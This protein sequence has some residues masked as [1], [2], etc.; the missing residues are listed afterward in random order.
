MN[1][2]IIGNGVTG[3]TAALRLRRRKPDWHITMVSGESEH[4]YS[5]PALMYIFMGHMR[6]EDTKPFEDQLWKKMRINLVHDW[7]SGIDTSTKRIEFDGPTQPLRYDKLLLA[8]GSEPNKFGWP[9]QDLDGVQGLYSL[10][11]LEL[12]YKNVKGCTDAVIVGG[13]L[14][15]IELAEMLHSQNIHARLLVREH[16]FWN[17]VLPPEESAMI[18]RVI[19]EDHIGLVLSDELKEIHDSDTGRVTGVSTTSGSSIDCQ[20]VGLTAGVRPNVKLAQASGI[21][22]G[23][24]ILTDWSLQTE[25]E[26]VWAAG[27]CAELKN[28]GDQRNL[29]QQVWY[30]G[31]MQANTAANVMCGDDE[32]YD[33]GIWFNS[34]KFLDLEYQT[35]GKVTAKP[36]DGEHQLVWQNPESRHLIRVV[37]TDK[38]VIGFNLLG[39]RYRH[40]VCEAWIRDGRPID[41]VLDNLHHANFDPEFFKRHDDDVRRTFKQQVA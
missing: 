40:E 7:V 18:N 11:D 38:Q 1:A 10:Q 37:Y 33:P 22:C 24:G 35:Y 21:P 3:V 30:T 41:F 12:L 34:A 9:G 31:R 2:V 29:I 8:T 26:D 15:G 32:T 39:V 36:G 16:S 17:N 28:Q 25:V 5:R 6:Y 19:E 20:L 4:H 23:R 27:D 13:G 14:I